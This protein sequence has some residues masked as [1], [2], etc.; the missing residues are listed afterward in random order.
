MASFNFGNVSIFHFFVVTI[1]LYLVLTSSCLI[2]PA[3]MKD[4][5]KD[6]LVLPVAIIL[7]LCLTG[8]CTKTTYIYQNGST[9]ND[10]EVAKHTRIVGANSK[11]KRKTSKAPNGRRYNS[12]NKYKRYN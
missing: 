9:Y 12:Q 5:I 8:G 2:L 10:Y 1:L 6:R 4:F 3:K 7:W 11:H